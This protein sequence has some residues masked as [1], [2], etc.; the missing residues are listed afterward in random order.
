MFDY[1]G[2][3]LH[4]NCFKIGLTIFI[5][6]SSLSIKSNLALSSPSSDVVK[7][8]YSDR[9]AVKLELHPGLGTNISFD[10]VSELVETIFLDN[11]SFISLTTNGCISEAADKV[12][13]VN[14]APSL[15]H[16]STIDN[17]NLPGVSKTNKSAGGKSLLTVI[18]R[19]TRRKRHTYIFNIKIAHPSKEFPHVALIRVSPKPTSTK[20]VVMPTPA[21]NSP[22][23]VPVL[24]SLPPKIE[25]QATN[26]QNI[27]RFI[28]GFEL[29]TNRGAY[30]GD[31]D[32]HEQVE[33]F[34]AALKKGSKFESCSEYGLTLEGV[35]NLIK[36]G[37]TKKSE[38]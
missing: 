24:E 10:D 32:G 1:G 23:V 35:S 37:S 7:Y 13:P 16:L 31:Y 3:I 4:T 26:P 27:D 6:I 22:I 33:N 36:L 20:V 19:D 30:K 34:I 21:Q 38:S 15:I 12:C 11:K 14:S 25:P 28:A 17:L 5:A 2:F 9:N 29:A 18:T 8:V